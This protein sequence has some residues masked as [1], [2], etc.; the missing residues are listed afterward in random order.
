MLAGDSGLWWNVLVELETRSTNANRNSRYPFEGCLCHRGYAY[1]ESKN[2]DMESKNDKGIWKWTPSWL[3]SFS[4]R[5]NLY[6]GIPNT[7]HYVSINF[8]LITS[9]ILWPIYP[10]Y[11]SRV[12]YPMGQIKRVHHL[13]TSYLLRIAWEL[14]V[15]RKLNQTR[16]CECIWQPLIVNSW[17]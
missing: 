5:S 13:L 7:S 8:S 14:F 17:S 2:L 9:N 3:H 6:T 12:R 1:R 11:E 16:R 4:V 15:P 10:M